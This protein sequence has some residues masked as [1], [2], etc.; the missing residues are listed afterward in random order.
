MQENLQAVHIKMDRW[1]LINVN[2]L[3]LTGECM[4]S[5]VITMFCSTEIVCVLF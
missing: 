1:M 5:V 2:V 3:D 4:R